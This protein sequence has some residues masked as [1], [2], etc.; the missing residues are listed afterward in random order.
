MALKQSDKNSVSAMDKA[1]T[2]LL[3]MSERPRMQVRAKKIETALLLVDI[4]SAMMP[5]IIPERKTMM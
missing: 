2:L 3:K 5:P 4:L 1:T